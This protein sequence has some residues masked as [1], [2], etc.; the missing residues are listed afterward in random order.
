MKDAMYQL[1]IKD[2]K[3]IKDISLNTSGK[4]LM[5]KLRSKT[6]EVKKNSTPSLSLKTQTGKDLDWSLTIEDIEIKLEIKG[7]KTLS[8]VYCF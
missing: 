1:Y 6:L 7:L 2:I 5:F 8:I 3:Y 4:Q